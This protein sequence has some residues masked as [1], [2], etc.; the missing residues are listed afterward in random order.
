MAVVIGNG[1]NKFRI[2]SIADLVYNMIGV[3][4]DLTLMVSATKWVV[5]ILKYIM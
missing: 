2:I 1:L 4:E 5:M 3:L